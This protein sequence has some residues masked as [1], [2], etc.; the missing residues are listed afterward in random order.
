M[1]SNTSGKDE[2]ETYLN[3]ASPNDASS[4]T[5]ATTTILIRIGVRIP[6]LH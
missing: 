6:P 5:D 3:V 4:K 1:L 2:A